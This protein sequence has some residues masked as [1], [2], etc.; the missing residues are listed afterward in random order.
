MKRIV[1]NR[2][3][4]ETIIEKKNLSKGSVAI[5]IGCN[6]SCLSA[7]LAGRLAM[8]PKRRI[9]L[10]SLLKTSFEETFIIMEKEHE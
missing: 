7:Y 10:L 6:R 8:R 1:L 5:I 2:D 4:V 9:K 3:L